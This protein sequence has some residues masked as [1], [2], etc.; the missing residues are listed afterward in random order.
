M[1]TITAAYQNHSVNKTK[2]ERVFSEKLKTNGVDTS[3]V[4]KADPFNTERILQFHQEFK[5]DS[6][7]YGKNKIVGRTGL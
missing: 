2:K 7:G 5:N 1:K 3:K 6:L 4:F